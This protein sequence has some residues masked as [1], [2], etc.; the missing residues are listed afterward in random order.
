M[1]RKYSDGSVW[2]NSIDWDDDS[3]G[4]D[5]G[6]DAHGNYIVCDAITEIVQGRRSLD[7][8]AIKQ[9]EYKNRITELEAE[10]KRLKAPPSGEPT[11]S[12]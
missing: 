8:F 2:G 3:D 11:D 4:G 12:Q 7:D 9:K 10:I 6:Y 5:G 1:D